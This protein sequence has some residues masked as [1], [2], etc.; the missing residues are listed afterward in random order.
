MWNTIKRFIQE[1][2]GAALAKGGSIVLFF[3]VVG[4]LGGYVLLFSLAKV[5]GELSVGI[6][7]VAFTVV[8][9]GSTVA[10]WG[11]DTVLVREMAKDHH[12]E[13][14]SRKLYLNVLGRVL[15]LSALVALGSYLGAAYLTDLFFQNTP[16]SVIATAAIT[17]VPFTLMLLNAEVF[18]AMGRS[19][20]F[21]LNQH[22]TIYILIGGLLFFLPFDENYTSSSAAQLSLQLL[23]VIS[24]VF[25]LW[26]TFYILRLQKGPQAPT[27]QWESRLFTLGT[28]MLISSSLF[29]VISWSDTLMLGYFLPEDQ[30]GM[31]RIVFK[32]ATLI[33]FAQ[34]ALN[35]VVAPMVS[36]MSEQR[37]KLHELAH[38]VAQ[39]NLITAGPIFLAIVFLGPI[40]ISLFGV[41]HANEAYPWL[42]LLAVGQL[43]N[44]FAGPVLNILNMTGYEKSAQNTML[45]IAV[46]NIV[47]NYLLI[48]SYGPLGAAVA[49]TITMMAWN[50]WAAYLVFKYHGVIAVPFLTKIRNDGKG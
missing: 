28:P 16:Q 32:I 48:P 4:A 37:E 6:Y 50:I 14:S 46:L 30:V 49:T 23:F 25:F 35:T 22:G 10:R 34:F 39:L 31:Y 3:K 21:S 13:L 2:T 45:V 38:K 47:F 12:A 36:A 33:T 7:E 20:L 11:L 9:I 26:T 1:P 19:L 44:A 24:A 18:R 5:G 29:L 42:I 43:T 17:V 15:I 8:L 27:N 40:L 41:A